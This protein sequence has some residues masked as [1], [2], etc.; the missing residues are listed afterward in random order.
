LLLLS[1][2]YPNQA[3][4]GKP[5]KRSE[6]NWIATATHNSLLPDDHDEGWLTSLVL[7]IILVSPAEKSCQSIQRKTL[8]QISSS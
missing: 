1:T 3:I 5:P 7:F 2:I 4:Q 8:K 6:K